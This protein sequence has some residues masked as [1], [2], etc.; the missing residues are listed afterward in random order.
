[1]KLTKYTAIITVCLGCAATSQAALVSGL[2]GYYDGEDNNNDPL[3]S[4]TDALTNVGV[5]TGVAGGIAG[6]AFEFDD[7]SGD[8]LTALTSYSATGVSDLG[9]TFTIAAWYNLDTDA[10]PTGNGGNRHFIWENSTD[11]DFSYWIDNDGGILDAT[12]VQAM[13]VDDATTNFGTYTKGTWQH[14]A[15]TIVSAG[16]TTTVTTF[17]DGVSVGS[18]SG[19]TATMGNISPTAGL[20]DPGINFGRARTPASDRPFDGKI[21]EIG[22]WNRALTQQEISDAVTLGNRGL[23]LTDAVPEPSSTALLGLGGLAIIWR[24][25]K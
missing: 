5:D 16:G 11:F 7:T 25:R 8:T 22:I 23:R 24:R 4:D 2:V 1:M 17:V 19:P 6:N 20:E 14:V 21:D 13:F 15:Q 3:A 12:G 9:D 18:D 10:D